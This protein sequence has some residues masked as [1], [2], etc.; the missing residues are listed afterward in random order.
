MS[1]YT[2]SKTAKA[3]ALNPA[4]GLVLALTAT[5]FTPR[6]A[7]S[8]DNAEADKLL[9]S[10]REKETQAQQLRA[11]ASAA[12]QKAA[13]DEL[14]ASAEERQARILSARALQLLKAD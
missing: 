4:L 2:I 14:E 1:T 3:F 10:A 9:A 11:A 5:L 6:L 12:T 8:A 7:R 13:D